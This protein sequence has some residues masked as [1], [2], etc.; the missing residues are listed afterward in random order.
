MQLEKFNHNIHRKD[1]DLKAMEWIQIS[2]LLLALFI[3]LNAVICP[4]K[5]K[6]KEKYFTTN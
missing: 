6:S 5:D 4:Q 1:K 3:T 2:K